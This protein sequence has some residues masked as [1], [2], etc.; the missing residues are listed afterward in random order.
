MTKSLSIIGDI[1][2]LDDSTEIMV[3]ALSISENYTEVSIQE[4]TLDASATDVS[5]AFG[6]VT[7]SSLVVLVP[8]YASTGTPLNYLTGK[9]NGGT[10]NIKF[11]KMFTIGGTTTNGI[12]ALTLSNP[13]TVLPVSVK[14]YLC[15]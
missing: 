9:V 2:R 15:S 6:G 11:G 5:I 10:E 1:K 14:V 7:E 13:D 8:V 4:V 3:D 12:T